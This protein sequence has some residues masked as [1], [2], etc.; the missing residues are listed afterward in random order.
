MQNRTLSDVKRA[1]ENEV[2]VMLYFWKEHCNV[3]YSLQPKLFKSFKE[4]F[5]AIKPITINIA[6]HTNIATHFGVFSIPI[7]IIFLDKKEFARV[8]RN[9]SI[10]ALVNQ[11]QRPYEMLTS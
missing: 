10:L 4:N 9:V 8:G 11:I 7:A 6:T 3:C 5:P 2:G 1:I